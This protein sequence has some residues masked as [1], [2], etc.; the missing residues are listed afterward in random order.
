MAALRIDHW[1]RWLTQNKIPDKSTESAGDVLCV[2]RVNKDAHN[3][4]TYTVTSQLEDAGYTT[5][6]IV[7]IMG[8]TKRTSAYFAPD[9]IKLIS[10]YKFVLC[11]ENSTREGY[12]TEKIF[13]AFMAGTIPIYIGPPDMDNYINPECY[14]DASKDDWMVELINN[15]EEYGRIVHMDKIA[16]NYVCP[17]HIRDRRFDEL[18]VKNADRD[19]SSLNSTYSG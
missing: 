14:I 15:P 19:L 5:G 18:L 1:R 2:Q 10:S 16:V 11:K 9:L 7:H 8:D 4:M 12:L 13:N 3:N 6:D 17:V